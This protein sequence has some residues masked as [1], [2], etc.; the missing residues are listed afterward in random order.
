MSAE[1]LS[2]S[3]LKVLQMFEMSMDPKYMGSQYNPYDPK[4][5]RPTDSFG[6]PLGMEGDLQ[7]GQVLR[8]GA[9]RR[10]YR[11]NRSASRKTRRR[12][13]SRSRSTGRRPRFSLSL[14]AQIRLRK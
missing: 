8:G 1:P 5:A 7:L 4:T 9:R 13:A 6:N 3:D 12:A 11:G 10:H 14:R 2:T